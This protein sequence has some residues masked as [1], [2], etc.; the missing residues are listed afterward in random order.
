MLMSMGTLPN[1][2]AETNETK[3]RCRRESGDKNEADDG[4]AANRK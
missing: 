2:I 1:A 4:G 3:S